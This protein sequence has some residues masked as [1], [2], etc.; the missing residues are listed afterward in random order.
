MLKKQLIPI[1]LSRDEEHLVQL[2]A[3]CARQCGQAAYLVGGFVRDKLLKRISKDIDI[4]VIG[5]GIELAKMVAAQFDP[6]PEL[7]QYKN[8][9]TALLKLGHRDLEFVGARRESYRSNSRKPIVENGTLPDDLSRRDFTVNALAV[10]LNEED[11]GMV[12]D[13]FDGLHD[14]HQKVLRTPLDPDLTFSDDPLRMMR[15]IRFA[16]QLNFRIH[17][18]TFQSV[19]KNKE[20]IQI[21]SQERITDELQKIIQAEKPSIGFDLLFKSGLLQIIFPEFVKLYGVEHLEGKGHKD[22]FYHTLQV[23]DNVAQRSNDQWLRWAAILHDI[24]KPETKRFD[25]KQGWTF[26]GHEVIGARRVPQIFRRL[27]LPLDEKMKFV[28]KMVLLHLRPIGLSQEEVTDS[29]MRRLLFEAGDDLDALM[30][31]CESDITSKNQTKV[32]SYLQNFQYVRERLSEVEEK[33]KMRNW[34][35]PITGEIIMKTFNKPPGK[36]IGI[37]KEAVREAILDGVIG[38]NFDEA[39]SF[40]LQKAGEIGWEKV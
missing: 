19:I 6:S 10:S 4:T 7:I 38:N 8:F 27:K 40:M 25:K 34:Q 29:A 20:R 16:T 3:S 14:L 39:F 36:E 2:I 15:A 35:P 11:Y 24:A 32:K 26:H 1:E 22:N 28:Q 23:L 5:S 31:L 21:I 9:G 12:L 33:D 37:I 13:A 30:I 18:E 17:P